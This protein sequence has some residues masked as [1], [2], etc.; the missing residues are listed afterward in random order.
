MTFASFA[1]RQANA[2]EE[3]VAQLLILEDDTKGAVRGLS[4]AFASTMRTIPPC[5]FALA[6][7]FNHPVTIVIPKCPTALLASVHDNENDVRTW[8]TVE[9][10]DELYALG[11]DVHPGVTNFLFDYKNRCGVVRD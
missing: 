7:P 10:S 9:D 6:A 1:V 5:L 3:T 4:A 2:L 11:R 8:T